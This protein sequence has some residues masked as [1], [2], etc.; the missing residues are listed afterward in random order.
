MGVFLSGAL[1]LYIY[2]LIFSMILAL[3]RFLLDVRKWH[4]K[5]EKVHITKSAFEADLNEP[6]QAAEA[7]E[8]VDNPV[9]EEVE[10]NDSEHS[11]CH[12]PIVF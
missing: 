7:A 8:P 6:V 4:D 12:S 9:G 10:K 2:T 5:E 3:F 1:T 11:K